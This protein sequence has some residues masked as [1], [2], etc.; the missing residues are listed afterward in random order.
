MPYD[1]R[2]EM[3]AMNNIIGILRSLGADSCVTLYIVGCS[4]SF[5]ETAPTQIC[6]AGGLLG[7][8]LAKCTS[9]GASR[10]TFHDITTLGLLVQGSR[11]DDMAGDVHVAL[12]R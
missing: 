7:C 5:G 2:S 10:V 12:S 9:A 11:N 6:G 8:V 4:Y 3:R 1:I